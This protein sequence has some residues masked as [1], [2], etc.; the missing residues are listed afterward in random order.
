M[1]LFG[2]I[3]RKD[4][5]EEK[6]R[7][8]KERNE[9]LDR[10]FGEHVHANEGILNQ[11]VQGQQEIKGI[12]Q[13]ADGR[14]GMQ[15]RLRV[16]EEAQKADTQV[17]DDVRDLREWRNQNSKPIEE[18]PETLKYIERKK[19]Q[20]YLISATLGFIGLGGLTSLVMHFIG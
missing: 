17:A 12:L 7:I 1:G 8:R 15:S 10:R 20:F 3:S 2:G 5:E 19:G 4:F 11:L 18:L 9:E 16:L 6:E 13:G 14:N